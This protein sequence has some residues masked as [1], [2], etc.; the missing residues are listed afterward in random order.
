M[1]FTN[2]PASN[3]IAYSISA[4]WRNEAHK[5]CALG[6]SL[7][8]FWLLPAKT[9]PVGFIKLCHSTIKIGGPKRLSELSRSTSMDVDGG[10]DSRVNQPTDEKEYF[11][12][13]NI[14]QEA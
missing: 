2:Q 9:L 13:R 8:F 11:Q 1:R 7:P 3:A 6:S 4:V 14:R 5:C 10:F 12:L